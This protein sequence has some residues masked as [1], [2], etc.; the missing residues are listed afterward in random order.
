MVPQA[1][2]AAEAL[3][4]DGIHAEIVDL[5]TLAPLDTGTIVT[6]VRK[7]GRVLIVEEGPRTGGFAA[8][9]ACRIFEAAYD[10]LDAPI[11]RLACPDC[12]L[13]A[14]KTLEAACI[15]NAESIAAEARALMGK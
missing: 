8:E 1:E 10:S 11:R 6:S 15:P 14:A 4:V 13:P 2:R 9:I 3:A 5:R 7:T 12:P